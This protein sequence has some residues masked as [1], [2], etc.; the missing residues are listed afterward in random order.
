MYLFLLRN[1]IMR[2]L[3]LLWAGEKIPISFVLVVLCIILIDVLI[4]VAP[5]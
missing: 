4:L 3:L 1:I 5:I 2:P